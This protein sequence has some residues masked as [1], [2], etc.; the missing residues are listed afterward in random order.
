MTAITEE[1][2]SVSGI[3]LSK[4]F[5]QQEAAVGRFRVANAKLAALADPP[6][7]GRPLVLHDRG[8]GL[9]HHARVRVLAGRLAGHPGRP[10]RARRSATSWRSRRSSRACSSRSASCSTS[11]SRC[12]GALAL[13]DRIFEYLDLE[14]GIEDAPDAVTLDRHE[15]R[16]AIRFR[17]V[18][19]RYPDAADRGPRRR[20]AAAGDGRARRSGHRRRRGGRAGDAAAGGDAACP[21]RSRTS[22]SASSR[23]SWWRSWATPARARR[24]PPTWCRGCT[25]WTTG[26]VEIDGIDVRQIQLGEPGRHHRRS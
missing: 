14:P 6:E 9:Q 1:T 20:A 8:H 18:C 5:G 12:T 16:G 22:T 23:A 10:D 25:T 4:T 19:F 13:F 11:R 26:A 21:S 7:H 17:H 3:L 15:V 24:P 2:L